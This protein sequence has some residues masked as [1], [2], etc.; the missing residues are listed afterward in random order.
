M[1]SF[2]TRVQERPAMKRKFNS[3]IIYILRD[4]RS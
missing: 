1:H 2:Q 3:P 4:K